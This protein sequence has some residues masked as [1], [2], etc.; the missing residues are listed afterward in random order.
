[1]ENNNDMKLRAESKI[2]TDR[3]FSGKTW[4]EA[5][6]MPLG[7]SL[8]DKRRIFGEYKEMERMDLLRIVKC[9]DM[10]NPETNLAL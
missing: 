5:R 9:T 2:Y 7:I 4:D 3:A 1:M 6:E 8:R 10:V